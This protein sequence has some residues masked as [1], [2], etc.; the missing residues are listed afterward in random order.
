MADLPI[1][2]Q[3][4]GGG[5]HFE[6]NDQ[7]PHEIVKSTFLGQNNGGHWGDKPIFGVVGGFRFNSIH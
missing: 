4:V 6:Q 5:G 1:R 7:K 3:L 2:G